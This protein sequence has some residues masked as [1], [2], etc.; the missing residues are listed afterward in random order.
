MREKNPRVLDYKYVLVLPDQTVPSL[1]YKPN[2][3]SCNAL[4][5]VGKRCCT[6]TKLCA[7]VPFLAYDP[8]LDSCNSLEAVGTRYCTVQSSL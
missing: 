8:N 2:P 1:A 3:D 5:A 7:I 6:V 4:Q